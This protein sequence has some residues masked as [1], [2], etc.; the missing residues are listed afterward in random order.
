MV[1][2]VVDA[3][4]EA[5]LRIPAIVSQHHGEAYTAIEWQFKPRP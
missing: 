2:P 5:G 4:D 1:P 3:F